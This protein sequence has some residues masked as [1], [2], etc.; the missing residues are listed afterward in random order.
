MAQ[1]SIH[2]YLDEGGTFVV[3]GDVQYVASLC[4]LHDGYFYPYLQ[5]RYTGIAL[6]GAYR[7]KTTE[8][9]E[10]ATKL[11]KSGLVSNRV[12]LGTY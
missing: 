4:M 1:P 3:H 5:H 8:Y 9:N 7:I 12:H 2:I 11:L 6:R 10:F